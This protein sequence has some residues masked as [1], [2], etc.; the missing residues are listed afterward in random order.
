MSPSYFDSVADVTEMSSLLPWLR[1]NLHFDVDSNPNY[2]PLQV[3]CS[4]LNNFQT[5]NIID[6]RLTPLNALN[7]MSAGQLC[8]GTR[9]VSRDTDLAF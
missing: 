7:A 4:S 5:K 3:N 8:S 1:N 6:D 2:S 9:L